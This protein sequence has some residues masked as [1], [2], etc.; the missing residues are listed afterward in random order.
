MEGP[1]LTGQILEIAIGE[2]V[3]NKVYRGQIAQVDDKNLVL[4]V[5]GFD[6]LH[7][8]DLLKG[9][10]VSLRAQYKGKI[11]YGTSKLAE[12][13]K[14]SSPYVVVRRPLHLKP[15]ERRASVTLSCDFEVAYVPHEQSPVR[16][17][18]AKRGNGGSVELRGVPEPFDVGTSLRLHFTL[19]AKEVI[20][21]EGEVCRVSRDPSDAGRYAMVVSIDLPDSSR[22]ARLVEALLSPIDLSSGGMGGG[23]AR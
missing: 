23:S 19:G 8:V 9:T 2:R 18:H 15:I 11:H 20:D 4:H 1:F 7:F 3:D 13:F 6:P 14:N 22:G 21:L 5:P 12:H 10:G 16:P 17:A